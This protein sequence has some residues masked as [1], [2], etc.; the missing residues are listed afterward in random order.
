MS[1]SKKIAIV[2]D[3]TS[4]REAID[5]LLRSS[6]FDTSLFASAID[7]LN[8][9]DLDADLLLTDV[10]MPGM[11]G[12]EL[13]EELVSRGSTLPVVVITALLD[14]MISKRAFDL[15]AVACLLKPVDEETLMGA[16]QS[17]LDRAI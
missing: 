7:F 16:I 11:T 6:G 3:D 17:A 4:L 9:S 15:G 5:N 1:L 12:L 10:K 2:E 8:N 14:P 13:Q